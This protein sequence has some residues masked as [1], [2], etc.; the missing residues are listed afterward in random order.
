MRFVLSALNAIAP[1]IEPG[2]ALDG[3]S[4]LWWCDECLCLIFWKG[5]SVVSLNTSLGI[6]I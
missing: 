4:F 1:C 3:F 6:R 5:G 2:S